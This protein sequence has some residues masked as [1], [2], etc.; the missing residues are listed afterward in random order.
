MDTK[1]CCRCKRELPLTI[2]YFHRYKRSK[3]GYK[4]LCKECRGST[5][6]IKQ[7][8]KVYTAKEGYKY[9]GKCKQQLPA[10]EE[11]FF[12]GKGKYG[13]HNQCKVCEGHSYG[14]YAPNISLKA[15]YGYKFCTKCRRELPSNADYFNRN[16]KASDGLVTVCKECMGIRFRKH[17][18]PGYKICI[19][20]GQEL[21]INETY[22]YK[23][24]QSKDG[25]EGRCLNCRIV[26]KHSDEWRRKYYTENRENLLIKSKDHR[27]KNKEYYQIKLNQRRAQKKN[28]PN[29]YTR[30]QWKE[31]KLS[32]N[33]KCAYCGEEKKLTQ[34]HFIPLSKG[35]EYTKNNILPA[36][37]SCN[38]GKRDKDFFDWYPRQ[39]FYQAEREK[40]ILEYLG[41][42]DGIQQL[43]ISI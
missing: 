39:P 5:F 21:P 28:L 9:C 40:K 16:K 23:S 25:Y 27:I 41:Y 26:Y 30:K 7:V 31:C 37:G 4:E 14:V 38:S 20:C 24:N 32:F 12:K 22:F 11:Y 6:G 8:N 2:E 3:D 35:G 17:A 33:N 42:K 19:N 15:K 43:S 13:Y 10:T 18:K 36:C 34:E 29:N 1:T